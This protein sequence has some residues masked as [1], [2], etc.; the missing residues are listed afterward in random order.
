MNSSIG[1]GI[2]ALLV[3]I[4]MI[5]AGIII[6][7]MVDSFIAKNQETQNAPYLKQIRWVAWGMIIF[8]IFMFVIVSIIFIADYFKYD[9]RTNKALPL[10]A[11]P[12]TK[13]ALPPAPLAAAP[14]PS[15]PLAAAP[16][17]L[18][19]AAAPAPLAGQAQ[20][21]P[22]APAPLAGR[23]APVAAI[24]LKS[25]TRAPISVV[26]DPILK[27][28]TLSRT[29]F[30]A[31][32]AAPVPALAI[33][34]YKAPVAVPAYK[35]PVAVPAYKAPAA[36]PAYKAP[37]AVPA[38]KAP[39]AVPAYKAPVAAPVAVPAYKAPQVKP[40]PRAPIS[41][42]IDPTLKKA[43]VSGS[44]G[45]KLPSPKLPAPI[46]KAPAST[47]NIDTVIGELAKTTGATVTIF[48]SDPTRPSVTYTPRKS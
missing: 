2:I 13:K 25:D 4:A 47:S 14:A 29:A 5:A 41:V 40:D 45:I 44:A 8:A 28:A 38:Y 22:A 42:V 16:A 20:R 15:A 30:V 37:V 11:A 35:A 43:T 18:A 33:P 26:I 9:P 32:P 27:N 36:V 48:P 17:S 24:S 19:L 12:G 46:L 6:L 39:V 1:L 7:K 34:V 10:E 23:R 3:T 21:A 31:A